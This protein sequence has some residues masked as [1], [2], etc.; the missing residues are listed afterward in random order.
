MTKFENAVNKLAQIH[1]PETIQMTATH[2]VDVVING[3]SVFAQMK[4]EIADMILGYVK[5]EMRRYIN[6]VTGETQ[7]N[8]QYNFGGGG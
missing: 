6:P 8:Q 7:E 2:S 4:P 5:D 3:A 1:I